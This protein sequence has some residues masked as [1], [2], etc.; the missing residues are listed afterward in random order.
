MCKTSCKGRKKIFSVTAKDCRWDYY[1]GS[2]KGGQHRNKK[3]TAVRCTHIDSGAVGSS[4]EERNQGQNKRMTFKRMAK[5][6]K[7]KKWLR[8]ETMRR[9]GEMAAIE[10]KVDQQLIRETKVETKDDQ[11]RWEENKDLKITGI[12]T[13]FLTA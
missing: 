10:A 12:D 5:T 3:D 8:L 11:G 13:T 2:G 9:S 6:E 7:F 1:R 4:E